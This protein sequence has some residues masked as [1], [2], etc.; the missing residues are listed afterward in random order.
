MVINKSLAMMVFLW[1]SQDNCLSAPRKHHDIL[2]LAVSACLHVRYEHMLQ[3]FDKL[4]GKTYRGEDHEVVKANLANP[5]TRSSNVYN[6][7]KSFLQATKVTKGSSFISII[8]ISN[9]QTFILYLPI[10]RLS[11]LYDFVPR[12]PVRYLF[13]TP[14]HFGSHQKQTGN[15]EA[16]VCEVGK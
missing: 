11:K 3:L 12:C 13:V 16:S 4:C 10:A 6:F 2:E 15:K 9:K 14:L 5:A 8:L 7:F 1:R